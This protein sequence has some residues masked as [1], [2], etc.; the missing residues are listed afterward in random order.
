MGIH[1][2]RHHGPKDPNPPPDEDSAGTQWDRQWAAHHKLRRV[3]GLSA[4]F[5][6]MARGFAKRCP[7]CGRG[8]VV[9]GYLRPS[10]GC[11]AC[12]EGYDHIRTDDLA[13]WISIMILGHLLLPAIIS[14][15]RLWGPPFW[16]HLL[17][18]IPV[19]VEAIVVLLPH[20]KGMAL[21]LMWG[22]NIR[23]DEQQY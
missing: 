7:N 3:T 13:P 5:R 17:I 23:G 6:C 20:A 15:E 2:P 11:R 22:L 21:G 1:D 14:V 9:T 18:W 16:L 19:A 8:A 10:A 12:G 4:L